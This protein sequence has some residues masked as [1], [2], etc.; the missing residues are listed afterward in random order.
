MEVHIL[1][2]KN[3]VHCLQGKYT[4][5]LNLGSTSG[6]SG[7][8]KYFVFSERYLTQS[9]LKFQLVLILGSSGALAREVQWVTLGS[10]GVLTR[11]FINVTCGHDSGQFRCINEAVQ[12]CNSE[13]FRCTKRATSPETR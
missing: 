12:E 6:D 4:H 10:S 8:F 7:Q 5:A 13:K 1:I 3:I 9:F 2:L 11:Q